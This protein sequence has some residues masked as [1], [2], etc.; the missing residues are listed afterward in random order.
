M[1]RIYLIV[2]ADDFGTDADRNR[3]ILEAA[4]HGIVTSTTILANKLEVGDSLSQLKDVFNGRTGVH[5]NLTSGVPL[6]GRALTL[7]D[8]SGRFF[9]K[10]T[11]WQKASRRAFDLSEVEREFTAQINHLLRLG[12]RLDHIDGNNHI[13]VFPG[14]APVVARL[15]NAFSIARVRLPLELFTAWRQYAQRGTFKKSFIGFL[16]HKAAPVFQ[17]HSLRFTDSFAGIQL[18]KVSRVESLRAFVANL[19]TGTTELMCHPGY[20]GDG[21][22]PF[23]SIEREA[24]LKALTHPEVLKEI[25][26]RSIRLISYGEVQ[27]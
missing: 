27:S 1:A 19:H 18:P 3:G 6:G 23:S 22:N 8:L 21:S 26:L 15:A 5:L 13:H 16:A 12:V 7:T 24:E 10:T 14:I 11:A 20:A 25:A 4:Q 2:N 17:E 9:D